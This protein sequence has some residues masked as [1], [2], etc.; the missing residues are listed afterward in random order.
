LK[1]QK[2][3]KYKRDARVGDVVLGKDETVAGQTYKC[4]RVTKV[5]VG[6]DGKVRAADIECKVPGETEFRSTTR[7]IH[8]LVVIVPVEEQIIEKEERGMDQGPELGDNYEGERGEAKHQEEIE[9]ELQGAENK[10]QQLP[11]VEVNEDTGDG[12]Q[13][14]EDSQQSQKKV[15][16]QMPG[17]RFLDRME[18]ILDARSAARRRGSLMRRS[19]RSQFPQVQ[20]RGV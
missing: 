14:E 16:L 10:E 9:E 11:G 13:N 19:R 6:M 12:D 20:A 3:F 5:H 15:A 18:V 2:W 1:Q 8:K 7:P 4:A 17:I